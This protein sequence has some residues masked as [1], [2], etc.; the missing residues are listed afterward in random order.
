MKY[1]II[2]S[3]FF[4]LSC[5]EK[6]ETIESELPS[7]SISPLE[8]SVELEIYL[9][10]YEEGSMNV[11]KGKSYSIPYI[12][13]EYLDEFGDKIL[14]TKVY[15]GLYD[16]IR[17]GETIRV[18]VLPGVIT[19]NYKYIYTKQFHGSMEFENERNFRIESKAG[20][21]VYCELKYV[22]Q[23]CDNDEFVSLP[24]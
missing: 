21:H 12:E 11:R 18:L 13:I 16:K 22:R 24:K 20:D 23:T 2:I 6:I 7:S 14:R 5:G 10:P 19:V 4:L 8:P 1:L 17:V 9:S 15:D 3:T